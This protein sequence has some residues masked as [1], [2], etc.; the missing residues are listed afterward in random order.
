MWNLL[1]KLSLPSMRLVSYKKQVGLSRAT[2]ESQVI[3]VKWKWPK[4]ILKIIC[5]NLFQAVQQD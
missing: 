5:G 3:N 2:L 4:I 1:R